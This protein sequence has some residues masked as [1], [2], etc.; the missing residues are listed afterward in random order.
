MN[1]HI[2]ANSHE[3]TS[4]KNHD[5]E[6]V[7]HQIREVFERYNPMYL[8]ERAVLDTLC[9]SAQDIMLPADFFDRINHSYDDGSLI[10]I[11]I[12]TGKVCHSTETLEFTDNMDGFVKHCHTGSAS[13][14]D[15]MEYTLTLAHCAPGTVKYLDVYW[16]DLFKK[17]DSLTREITRGL[18]GDCRTWFREHEQEVATLLHAPLTKIVADAEILDKYGTNIL[19]NGTDG[20]VNRLLDDVEGSIESLPFSEACRN[21]LLKK[22][23]DEILGT[24]NDED[25]RNI[26]LGALEDGLR[27]EINWGE[28]GGGL[29]LKHSGWHSYEYVIQWLN[30]RRDVLSEG[31][32]GKERFNQHIARLKQ[33]GEA[34]ETLDDIANTQPEE[35]GVRLGEPD[36][37]LPKMSWRFSEGSREWEMAKYY[38]EEVEVV[39]SPKELRHVVENIDPAYSGY[40]RERFADT[41]RAVIDPQMITDWLVNGGQGDIRTRTNPLR[42]LHT[43]LKILLPEES[44]DLVKEFGI[45]G[46]VEKLRRYNHDIYKQLGEE[47]YQQLS[48]DGLVAEI[49]C[50]I[51][52]DM[53]GD[54]HEL[55]DAIM[56]RAT[57]W[58]YNR[59]HEQGFS[60]PGLRDH[61]VVFVNRTN[62][63][64]FPIDLPD[65]EAVLRAISPDRLT[66]NRYMQMQS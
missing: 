33:C 38:E 27:D 45:E 66:F 25:N 32:E 37:R 40:V 21:D 34:V 58:A 60:I 10:G 1:E 11:K 63:V 7:S 39:G 46:E 36:H 17:S 6:S 8:R 55:Y 4:D 54:D 65:G 12:E 23:K 49:A 16:S 3:V 43:T 35:L 50:R 31:W 9:E 42:M 57:A 48:D 44:N 13:L 24:L 47:G 15:I 26:W 64:K 61:L 41:V 18:R 5:H 28:E 62:K 19:V 51:I 22:V 59:I 53:C 20:M 29:L 52:D 14:A 56:A 30:K 2:L